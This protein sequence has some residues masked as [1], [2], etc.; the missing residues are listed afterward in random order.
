TQALGQA[1]R[2]AA[3]VGDGP[4]VIVLAGAAFAGSPACAALAARFRVL[5]WT[6]DGAGA[7]ALAARLGLQGVG[8]VAM[9]EAAIEG[10]RVA[11]ALGSAASALVLV[12]PRGLPLD[13]GAAGGVAA[14]L[15]GLETPKCVL[16]G[17]ADPDLGADAP[18]LWRRRLS[19]VNVV[20]V[21]GAGADIAA[22]R[23]QAF[24]SAAGD[25]LDRQARFAFVTGTMAVCG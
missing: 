12:S 9:G 25:F 16:L 14:L 17:L 21:H 8:L 13:E 3:D 18:A 2:A 20:L 5:A 15:K 4:P 7:A 24:A 6:G 1:A 23:P 11:E 19:R 22:D 10:L